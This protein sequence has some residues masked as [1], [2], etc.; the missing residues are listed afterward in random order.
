[1]NKVFK[2]SC[3]E[4]GGKG[5]GLA[6]MEQML[7]RHTDRI[8]AAFGNASI[9]IP[10]TVVLCT[11]LF[12][13][14]METNNLY[15]TALS[16][17]PD[18]RMLTCFLKASLPARLTADFAAFL[19]TVRRPIAVRSSSL[20]ED[21]LNQPFAGVYATCMIPWLDNRHQMLT[22]LANAIK[23]VYA[24]VF[25]R[26]SKAYATATQ[27]V[28][29]QEKMAIVLQ[30][31]VGQTCGNRFYP[32]I[33]GVARSLNFYPIGRERPEDGI[34][35]IALGF[36]KYI[37]DGGLALRFSPRHPH[38]I[39]QMS[40]LD[41][42]LR[43]TQT[44]FYALDLDLRQDLRPLTDGAFNLRKL[45]VREAEADGTLRYISSTY[46][47]QDGI[48]RD[49][50]Y[51][52]RS[53][54]V[55][56]FAGVLQGNVFPLAAILDFLLKLG[57]EETGQPVEIEFAVDLADNRNNEKAGAFYLLQL[58]PI[59]DSRESIDEDLSQ[60]PPADCLLYTASALG[61]GIMTNIFD[62]VY[63]KTNS[64]LP[65]NNRTIARQI[66]QLNRDLAC[67]NR[68]Y[69]LI[70]PGRWGSTDEWL[71]VPVKWSHISHARLI[72]ESGLDNYRIEPSQGTHFFQ[73]LT[74]LGAGYFTVN[75]YLP[76][77]GLFDEAF[78]NSHPAAT[79]T[80]HIR[81]VRFD[82]PLIVKID[83]K[84]NTGLV[85]KPRP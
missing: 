78:L 62:A 32:T 67:N 28:I 64:F 9:R 7:K 77:G 22:M 24:S 34:A 73:N 13:E 1:M 80:E 68:N 71:G 76:N 29:E 75:A 3:P 72:V 82:H 66:E 84:K 74:S 57:Q 35:A 21:S 18:E 83:G 52:G 15:P 17:I 26:D 25:Y 20:L 8:D 65:A 46:D 54:K 47:P 33:S 19:E 63:I 45:P 36:G 50:F 51:P 10:P 23:T 2:S 30:E 38:H 85:L 61:H 43:E 70:G 31:A 55:L 79:E 11:D 16:D 49:G 37:V 41:I 44:Q 42:A 58:R 6:F 60:T 4:P 48:L 39:L 59:V 27:N 40:D 56:S 53:R 69:I 5:R 12:D 81:H 14:F